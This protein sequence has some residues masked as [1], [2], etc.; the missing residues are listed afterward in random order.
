VRLTLAL[1]LPV[2]VAELAGAQD[3]PQPLPAV[4][5]TASTELVR[6]A[7]LREFDRRRSNGI[8]RFLTEADLEKDQYRKLSDVLRKLPGITFARAK[9]TPGVSPL[10]EFAVSSRGSA[11]IQNVS[12]IFGKNCPIAIWLDGVPVYR[13]LDRAVAP[14]AFGSSTPPPPATPGRIDEP[15]FDINSIMTQHIAA[16]EFYAG[17]ATMPPEL[18]ATQ[19]TCGALVIWTK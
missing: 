15:P 2:A 11:T 9:S 16:I 13:G 10:A 3:K 17:P 7:K 4:P 8:G 5:V 1:F 19:G 18:N 6:S 14:R 12:P